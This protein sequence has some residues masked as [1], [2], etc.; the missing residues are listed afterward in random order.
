MTNSTIQTYG[1]DRLAQ[2]SVETI[3]GSRMRSPPMVG[4]PAFSTIWRCGPS[5]RIGW[6]LP[7]FTFSHWISEPLTMKA[8]IS[9]VITAPP[10]RKVRYLN[11]RKKAN[12]SVWVRSE[13]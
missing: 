2:S 3:Q 12:W 5:L 8:K 4:V 11:S 7:C 6:P 1:L 9:A 10:E 13:R